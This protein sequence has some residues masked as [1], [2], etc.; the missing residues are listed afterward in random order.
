MCP[1]KRAREP[2]GS[3]EPPKYLRQRRYFFGRSLGE[4]PNSFILT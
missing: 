3:M 2:D 1:V 4:I